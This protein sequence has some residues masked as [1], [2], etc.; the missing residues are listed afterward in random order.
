VETPREPGLAEA[1]AEPTPTIVRTSHGPVEY[2]AFGDGPVV[3]ALHGAM[4]GCDQGL[5]LARAI[6][7]AGFRYVALSR[8]G[9]LGTP[10]ESGRTPAEQADLCVEVLDA[11]G[12]RAAALAAVS[13]GG[14]CALQLAL[15]HPDRCWGL[16]MVS[17]CSDTLGNRLP[18][19]WYVLKLVAR[20]PAL[21][22]V[23]RI[24]GRRSARDPEAGARRSIPDPV[25]RART[26]R[27][28]EAGPLLA[29]L[30]ASTSDRTALRIA[31]TEND[32]RE[33]R[34]AL[35]YPFERI[36][37]PVLAFHGV[38]DPIV[39]Y[40]QAQALAARAPN[41]ALVRVEGGGHVSLF[42]HLDAF[43][44][45]VGAFL[46]ANAPGREA[47]EERSGLHASGSGRTLG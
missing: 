41:A 43:R 46:R 4:G 27:H 31:G 45:R 39:P 42:T 1:A 44:E 10:L 9:Y 34:R 47:C 22:A 19:A 7:A 33:T 5:L 38:D 8:P 29:A 21:A 32:V 17:A 14:P 30:Q 12:V 40:A 11:L 24:Q 28:P 36:A 25:V 18:L 23:I 2:A 16:V 13:G 26:L 37:A 15:R 6:G 20:W 35:G 3:V